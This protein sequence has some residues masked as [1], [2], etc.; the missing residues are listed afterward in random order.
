MIIYK[1]CDTK[2]SYHIYFKMEQFGFYNAAISAIDE[3]GMATSVYADKT[4]TSEA[5]RP[6]STMFT[7]A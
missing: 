2:N 5:I 6:G 4:V 1:K 3:D 7:Q